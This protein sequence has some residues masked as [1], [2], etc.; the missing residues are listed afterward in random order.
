MVCDYGVCFQLD[1]K[2]IH[3]WGMNLDVIPRGG[4]KGEALEYLLKKLKAEGMSPVNTL[5]CGDSE[6][7][8][9]LFSIPDVHGVMVLFSCFIHNN[10][11]AILIDT[12]SFTLFCLCVCVCE[13]EQFSRRAT[14][15]AY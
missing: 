4:G 11:S 1:V 13:G 10:L 7:D 15:V 6:H 12:K 5:A 9:E 14:E 8:A 3:S 2:I